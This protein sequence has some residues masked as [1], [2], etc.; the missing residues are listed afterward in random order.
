[1]QTPCQTSTLSFHTF[2]NADFESA[3]LLA[4]A[5]S[6]NLP[7]SPFPWPGSG[8]DGKEKVKP[9]LAGKSPARNSWKD[10][11]SKSSLPLSLRRPWAKR[12]ACAWS[13]NPINYWIDCFYKLL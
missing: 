3:Q 11:S 10:Q 4:H 1:M 13:R 8:I 5:F 2:T 7:F 6:K 12:I 9:D